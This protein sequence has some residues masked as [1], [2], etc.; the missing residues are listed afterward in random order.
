VGL[1][2]GSPKPQR[3]SKRLAAKVTGLF[4]DATDKAVQLKAVHNALAP[5]SL[6]LKNAV[7]K[8]NLLAR[9]KL[10]I[11]FVDLRKMITAAGIGTPDKTFPEKDG[12][13][14]ATVV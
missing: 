13:A 4:V 3:Q 6:K 7:Q 9:S 14:T 2:L 1:L 12:V 5:C 10:P 11:S 8:K